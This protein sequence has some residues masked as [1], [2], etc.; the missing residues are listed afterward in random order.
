MS[1]L[2]QL[3]YAP[4]KKHPKAQSSI[5]TCGWSSDP[6]GKGAGIPAPTATRRFLNPCTSRI[7]Q[8]KKNLTC[9]YPLFLLSFGQQNMISWFQHISTKLSSYCLP[10]WNPHPLDMSTKLPLRTSTGPRLPGVVK[11]WRQV[12]E[13]CGDDLWNHGQCHGQKLLGKHWWRITLNVGGIWF[14]VD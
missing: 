2:L 3:H 13:P 5:P 9:F 4:H 1:N 10:F 14:N 6:L 12:W 7:W 11:N 8:N